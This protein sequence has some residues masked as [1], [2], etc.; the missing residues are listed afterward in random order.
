[1]NEQRSRSP[2]MIPV[3]DGSDLI[4]LNYTAFNYRICETE[5]RGFVNGKSWSRERR[6]F[7][8]RRLCAW[9]QRAIMTVMETEESLE[10]RL[11]R[12]RISQA[13]IRQKIAGTNS[14]IAL[15]SMERL[16]AEKHCVANG[17]YSCRLEATK[18]AKCR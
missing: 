10:N 16:R 18:G 11:I 8:G 14:I 4:A 17:N 3:L 2:R 6:G 5:V 9:E 12:G 15:D 13:S 1:M 7:I